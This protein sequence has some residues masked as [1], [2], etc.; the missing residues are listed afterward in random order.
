MTL[1]TFEDD[2][3]KV[4]C[5]IKAANIRDAVTMAEDKGYDVD[6]DTFYYTGK[7]E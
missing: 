7:G 5:R 6:F 4:I 2:N 1:F 3:G